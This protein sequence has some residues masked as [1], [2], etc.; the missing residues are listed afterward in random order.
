MVNGL[1]NGMSMGVH[2]EF[3][4]SDVRFLWYEK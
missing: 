1:A 4:F 2:C 3:G